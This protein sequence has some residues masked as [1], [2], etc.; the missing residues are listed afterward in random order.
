M[1]SVG[2]VAIQ[3]LQELPEESGR[4]IKA[5]AESAKSLPKR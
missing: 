2:S 4:A 1:D 5:I 3:S